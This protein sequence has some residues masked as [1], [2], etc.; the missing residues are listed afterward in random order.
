MAK[1]PVNGIFTEIQ[2]GD[3]GHPYPSVEEMRA[4]QRKG[5]EGPGLPE[6]STGKLNEYQNHPVQ[7]EEDK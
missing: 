5:S 1:Q 4:S 3:G 2:G 6:N 7:I